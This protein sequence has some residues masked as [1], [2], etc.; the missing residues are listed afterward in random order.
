MCKSALM[1]HPFTC[2][3][4][5][6]QHCVYCVLCMLCYNSH[7]LFATMKDTLH[8]QSAETTKL[9]EYHRG[10]CAGGAMGNYEIRRASKATSTEH[11]AWSSQQQ[12]NQNERTHSKSCVMQSVSVL[13]KHTTILN[14]FFHFITICRYFLAREMGVRWFD[15][16][17]LRQRQFCIF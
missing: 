15:G 7:V 13:A 3:I 17:H 16:I 10:I 2:S 14:C 8:I 11:A 1:I 12:S 6:L 9:R 4:D 5:V